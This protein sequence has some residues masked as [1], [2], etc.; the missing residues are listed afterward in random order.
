M[1]AAVPLFDVG[2]LFVIVMATTLANG[3]LI[4]RDATEKGDM[5]EPR[6]GTNTSE[7]TLPIHRRTKRCTCYTYK[8]KECVYYCHLDIIW[9][10]T[11]EHTVPYGLSFGS[12]RLKR[13]A[14]VR[15]RTRSATQR[16]ACSLTSDLHCISFCRQRQSVPSGEL[17]DYLPTNTT[18]I[19]QS[20]QRHREK[21]SGSQVSTEEEH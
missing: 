6:Q 20:I 10:N 18:H 21:Q 17:K 5:G 7:H 2:V 9:I 4:S 19:S 16:C 15:Q 3:F 8:D 1:A 12:Q 11:P 14:E 13:S